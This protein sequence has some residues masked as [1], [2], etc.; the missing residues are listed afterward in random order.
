VRLHAA[1]SFQPHPNHGDIEGV[2][3]MAKQTGVRRLL[4]THLNRTTRVRDRARIDPAMLPE[5]G[6]SGDV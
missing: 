3:E 1:A 2:M 6:D 4:L 5:P